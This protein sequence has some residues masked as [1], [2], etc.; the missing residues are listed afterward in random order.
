MDPADPN[1]EK[2]THGRPAQPPA[3]ASTQVEADADAD[4]VGRAARGSG[5]ETAA[6]GWRQRVTPC[7]ADP[8][9]ARSPRVVAS[10]SR[11]GRHTISGPAARCVA[12]P[13]S[14]AS[15]P[16]S[17][18]SA[19]L[20]ACCAVSQRRARPGAT[21]PGGQPACT[22]R[23]APLVLYSVARRRVCRLQ[24][25]APP[26]PLRFYPAFL[27]HFTRGDVDGGGRM[28][29]RRRARRISFDRCRRVALLLCLQELT[30]PPA[31]ATATARAGKGTVTS[32][33]HH[34]SPS[35]SE[36]GTT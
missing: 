25:P 34:V 22:R 36:S 3:G 4:R 17:P 11:A 19:L 8:P 1:G 16:P 12:F 35:H 28:I 2:R 13:A 32:T 26:F 31:T 20:H 7:P 9:R 10:R 27:L 14:P 21:D 15:F 30:L 23:C 5:A 29:G 18:P 24:A 33:P 6:R